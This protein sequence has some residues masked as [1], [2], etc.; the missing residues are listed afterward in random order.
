MNLL[1]ANQIINLRESLIPLICTLP[2]TYDQ[3]IHEM[4][5]YDEL[6]NYSY[7]DL[8]CLMGK[9]FYHIFQH[10]HNNPNFIDILR[11]LGRFSLN[12]FRDGLPLDP[13]TYEKIPLNRIVFCGGYAYDRDTEYRLKKD[14]NNNNFECYDIK[15]EKHDLLSSIDIMNFLNDKN[16]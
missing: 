10:Y 12:E 6:R 7:D 2:G 5:Y 1:T 13:I 16:S 4:T 9:N 11:K 15:I 8:Y 3:K 14:N